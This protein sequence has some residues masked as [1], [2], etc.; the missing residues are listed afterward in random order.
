M[1]KLLKTDI[2][3]MFRMTSFWVI[4]ALLMV[5]AGF[6][7]WSSCFLYIDSPNLPSAPTS[8][9]GLFLTC[10]STMLTLIF[11]VIF[12]SSDFSDGTIKNIASKGFSR[13][14]IYL[15][16]LSAV[17]I[18]AIFLGIAVAAVAFPLSLFLLKDVDTSS[19]YA[20]NSG[21]LK[22]FSAFIL[23]TLVYI[24]I[25]VLISLLVRKANIATTIVIFILIMEPFLIMG[26][27][28]LA[29][30]VFKSNVDISPYLIGSWFTNYYDK[31]IWVLPLYFVVATAIGLYFFKKRDI[32]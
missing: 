24:A 20:I 10:N 18:S 32:N 1:A 28:Y 25:T 31:Y 16:K 29:S 14:S 9:L 8:F 27:Q 5:L 21:D 4:A 17:I 11:A 7:T 6:Q 2:Y 15:S 22:I 19:F 26:L 30:N 23:A 12:S 13:V 3:K